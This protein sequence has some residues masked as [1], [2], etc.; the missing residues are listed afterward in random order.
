MSKV[1]GRICTRGIGV[2]GVYRPM[3]GSNLKGIYEA[4]EH[5]DGTITLT[6][7]GDP[8][9]NKETYLARD[10]NDLFNRQEEF[11]FTDKEDSNNPELQMLM[12]PVLGRHSF[13][14]RLLRLVYKA[15]DTNDLN[16]ARF[17]LG[18]LTQVLGTCPDT[19]RA[20][21]FVDQMIEKA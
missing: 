10:L 19:I 14:D 2:A 12:T 4:T 20:E 15:I 6:R 13:Y 17:R 21:D 7:I 3:G 5:E 18:Q 9:A 11:F 1:I 16:E 8:K